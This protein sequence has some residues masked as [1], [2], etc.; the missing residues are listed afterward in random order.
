MA[1]LTADR[2]TR[3]RL[4]D[5]RVSP[6]AANARIFVGALLMRNA[7]GHLVPGATATGSVGV[8][9]AQGQCNNTGGGAAA[10][11]V[12]WRVGTFAFANSGGGDAITL[13]DIGKVCLVVDDQTVARTHGGSTR[14]PAGIVEDLDAEGVWVRFD[15]ALTRAG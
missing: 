3:Q 6:V 14:S 13:A 10:A 4:G 8:G 1:A 15:G 12:R 9:V 5:F 2:N 7:A 11:S